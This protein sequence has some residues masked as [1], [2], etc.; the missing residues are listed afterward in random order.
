MNIADQF[1][2]WET[3]GK[4]GVSSDQLQDWMAKQSPD[5]WHKIAMSW[6]YD[7]E[8]TPLLWMVNQPAC[9]FG[10]A[11]QIFGTEG[12]NWMT[13]PTW[14]ELDHD[15]YRTSWKMCDKIIERWHANSFPTSE[16]KP[17]TGVMKTH[18]LME[19]RH[20]DAG[21]SLTWVVPEHV[22][23]YEGSREAQSQYASHDGQ[24]YWDFDFWR[25]LAGFT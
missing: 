25:K 9:D 18:K 3:E 13:N 14:Q 5:T 21:R 8:A 20:K 11:C 24:I 19:S 6:Q 17:A 15:S 2:L 12:H 10:T 7:C 23:Q 4:V 1:Q 22:Y 16:L